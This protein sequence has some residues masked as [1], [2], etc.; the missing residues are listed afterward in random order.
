M[1]FRYNVVFRAKNGGFRILSPG[2]SKQYYEGRVNT[3]EVNIKFDTETPVHCSESGN[4]P[5][6]DAKMLHIAKDVTKVLVDFFL[7]DSMMV[8]GC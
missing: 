1:D 2:G 3:K 8:F 5:S 4:C 6:S 7:E